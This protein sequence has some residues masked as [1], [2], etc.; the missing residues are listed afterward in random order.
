VVAMLLIYVKPNYPSWI[1]YT[2][3][4][5]LIAGW[6]F[7]FKKSKHRTWFFLSFFLMLLFIWFTLQVTFVQNLI[8]KRVT[9]GLSEKL[10]ATVSIRHIEYSFFD[11]MDLQGLLVKDRQQD[12]L[13]YAG[14]AKI[15]I[16]DWFFLKEKP[17]IS[18]VS[19]Q[20]G[21]VDMHRTDSVWN[22]QFLADFFSSPKKDNET[23]GG[24]EFDLKELK[25][26]NISVKQIDGWKGRDMI[27]SLKDL[28]LKMNAIDLDKKIIDIGYL[29]L[30]KPFFRQYDYTGNRDKLNIPRPVKIPDTTTKKSDNGWRIFAQN[31]HISNG[32][33]D[34]GDEHEPAHAGKFDAKH[35]RFTEIMA[36]FRH[37]RLQGD[38]LTTALNLSTKEHSGFTVKKLQANMKFTP[39]IMEFDSLDLVTGKSRLGNYYAMKYSDFNDDMGN[40]LHKVN[41]EGRFINSILSSEDLAFFAPELTSWKKTFEIKGN[42]RGTIDKLTVNKMLIKTGNSFVDG[43][44]SLKGLPDINNT[45]IDFKADE[46]QTSF[47]DMS[48]IIPALKDV[49]QPNLKKLGKITYQGNYTGFL[50]DF[51]AFGTI[52]TNLGTVTGDVNLKLPDNRPPVYSGKVLTRGFQLGQFLDNSELGSIVFNG[53]IKGSGFSPKNLDAN[54]DGNV[55]SI[56]YAG[57]NYQ[58]II[59]NADF[60]KKL[61]HGQ[62]SIN[63]PN[64]VLTTLNG[65]I[66]LNEKEPQFDFNAQL[67]KADFKKLKLTNDEFRL[68][69]NFNLNFTG[70]NID[71]FLGTAKITDAALTHNEF[72]LSFD[73]LILQSQINNGQKYLALHSNEIDAHLEGNFKVLE[74]PDAFKMFLSR[75]YPAYIKKPSKPVVDQ[76]FSFDIRTKTIDPYIQLIDPKLKGFNNSVIE[77]DLKL[78]E[79][80]LN[81]SADVPEFSYDNKLFTNIRLRSRGTQDSL[82]TKIDV[83]DVVINDSLHLPNTN[84]VFNSF[85]DTSNVS[86]K[87]T[88]SKTVS[89]ASI[90][91]RVITM[92]DG[93]NIHFFPSSFI[94]NEK[95]WQLEKDG[96]LTFR[97]KSIIASGIKFIQNNQQITVSTEP[98]SD[99]NADDVL[100][101]LDK[102]SV[103]DFTSL[104]FADPKLEGLA[105][106]TI[107]IKDPLS[108]P[109]IELETKLEEFRTGKDSVGE[110]SINGTYNVNSG[111]L[112]FKGVSDKNLNNLFD[113]DGTINL[114]DSTNSQTLIAI[115]SKKFDL[116]LLNNYLG[117][118]FSDIRGFAN[119]SDLTMYGN[120]NNLALTG[121][122][123]IDEGSLIV[124]YTQC[125]YK[126]KNESILFNPNEI[127]FGNITL[128]DTLNNT[129]TLSGKIYHRF[130]KKTEF[131]NIRLETNRMLVLNTTKKDNSQFYGK[132]IGKANLTISG[133]EEAITM[134]I[135]GEPSTLD[136]SHIYII[137]GNSI[138]NGTVDYIDFVQFGNKMEETFRSKSA[139]NV[140]VNMELTANPSCK[141]DVILDETTGDIIKGEGQGLLKISV[142]NKEPLTINGRYDITRGQY[143]FNFQTFLKKFFTVNSGSLVW[144]GDPYKARIDILAEYLATQVNFETLAS[145]TP[146]S[147]SLSSSFGL[148][149]DLK[150]VAHL[151]E[152][153][154]KPKIEFNL[155]LPAGSNITDFLI[156][157][158]L[159]QFKQD[160][161]DLNKQ[162]TSLLLFN[163]FINTRQGFINAGSGY[164]VISSTIGGVV[165]NAISGFFNKFLQQYIKNLTVNV[166]L[167]SSYDDIQSNVNK[168]QAA[169]KSNFVYTL[170]NGRLII[171]AG[172]NVD[173]NNPY[174]TSTRNNNVLV[175]PDITAEW[176]LTQD[177][178]VRVVGF[179]RTNYDLIGQRNRTG[180]SIA[181]RK[182]VDKLSQIFKRDPAKVK[183]KQKKQ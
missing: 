181:Y 10:N 71:N 178:R 75:Y 17:V 33:F 32:I 98:S 179:N 149:S 101:T 136:S 91:A 143:T 81:V 89:D 106:G 122:A 147:G 142:G 112:K 7:V 15:N 93:V 83:D 182:D 111:E 59:I 130:F 16:S 62:V 177:G 22:Y 77:G 36:D 168:L 116:S 80:E 29:N 11:K 5:S 57:Y 145:T 105:T 121:T 78:K 97:K 138:E 180:V 43:D 20:D 96:E 163:S 131:D 95:K 176:I 76:N 26:Q 86:I 69:G 132:V 63:D 148:K 58:N 167:N 52:T 84:L 12:T 94:V 70:S 141:V 27:I 92:S 125:K 66:N 19:L 151:T 161:N 118:L 73:S 164:N 128:N 140:M 79:N 160:E 46:L 41:L 2:S 175:T 115:K 60:K 4:V 68:K 126:F 31:I 40:F 48:D 150:V 34:N 172:I 9:T 67:E 159:E 82:A 144:D 28:E 90:N 23:K 103:D 18:Y 51:V 120:I 65:T 6:L 54:F 153:L 127:D 165:S 37:V 13:L 30:D 137:S 174:V 135:S 35:I 114:K 133:N 25:L 117:D 53:K 74:L 100:I 1:F 24:L 3:F 104:A 113:V 173:Y 171:T 50:N 146:G 72:P 166:D 85:N 156:L 170:L 157:K 102:V 158:R 38:S 110:M 123:N 47:E 87:T 183:Q 155:V 154:L 56:E 42:A 119:T 49:T 61:F 44:I 162:V 109:Y 129:A 88:A 152:T 39:A 55:H 107:R 139:T 64:L 14:I 99:G 169:A 8:V 124:N 45:F 21:V 134:N 108:K